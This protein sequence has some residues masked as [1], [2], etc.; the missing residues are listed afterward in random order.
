MKHPLNSRDLSASEITVAIAA[1]RLTA[2]MALRESLRRIDA[3]EPTLR[4]FVERAPPDRLMEDARKLDEAPAPKGRLHGIPVAIKEILDVAGLRCSWGS[5]IHRERIP[6]AD[7]HAVARLRAEGALVVGT[8]VSTEYAIA[9]AGPTTNPHASARSPGG[10]SSGSAA[11]VAAGMVPLALGSQTIGS[12]VRPATYCGVYGFKPSHG[13]ISTQGTMPLSPL[14][15]DIG[16]LARSIDDIALAA[17]VLVDGREG[18][19]G[20]F[21]RPRSQPGT[22]EH[23]FTIV[24]VDAPW[25]QG[26]G[27]TSRRALARARVALEQC[28]ACVRPAT[29]A[30]RFA[31]ATEWLE[32]IL[33][34]D[35]ATNHGGDR[36]RAG[37]LMSG[38]LR[39]IIDRG[40]H[41]SEPVYRQA[42]ARASDLMWYFSDLVDG[43]GVLLAAATDGVAPW[44]HE[45]TGS[46]KIQGPY[47]LAGLAVLAVPTGHA[48][49]MPIGVQ[50]ATTV[51]GEG[52]LFAAAR[53]IEAGLSKLDLR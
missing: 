43:N 35:I 23:S 21:A 51:G 38:R 41:V 9:A 36:D 22:T 1:G 2:E 33:D 48:K 19:E 40:R 30:P 8:T 44:L 32:T 14:L 26:V 12:I 39:A 17:E 3:L 52:R 24:P 25:D 42:I 49:G 15:D 18:G 11:A 28:G 31:G 37:E 50:L 27:S 29:V 16:V 47:T 13:T 6:D 7:A 10:S 45:G 5:P 34:H 20:L 53:A 46:P 4:A